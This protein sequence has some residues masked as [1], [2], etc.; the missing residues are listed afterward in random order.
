MYDNVQR[1]GSWGEAGSKPLTSAKPDLHP[2]KVLLSLWW[3]WKDV[4]YYELLP[5]KETIN[6]DKYCQ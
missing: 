4:I 5:N 6:S 1:K 3:D 2:K